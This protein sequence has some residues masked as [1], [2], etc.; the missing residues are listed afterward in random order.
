[1][2]ILTG[3]SCSGKNAIQE[4]LIK[5]G[6]YKRVVTYT[7]RPMREGE[8]NGVTYHFISSYEFFK[9][10]SEGFFAE[11]TYYD[12]ANGER[13]YYGTS[14]ECFQDDNGVLIMNPDGLRAIEAHPLLDYTTFYIKCDNKTLKQRLKKRGDN[15][16]EAKRRFKADKRDFKY[17]EYWC[18]YIVINNDSK[19]IKDV[20]DT[21]RT[22]YEYDRRD[23]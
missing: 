6:K 15:V 20:A 9:K 11:V 18:D 1:M 5:D 21:I 17:I 4:E 19:N 3:K 16:K 14:S 22:V 2:I 13:W 12:V 23:D 10:Q 7:T 8:V